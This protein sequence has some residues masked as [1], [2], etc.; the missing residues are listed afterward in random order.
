M[1]EV[2]GLRFQVVL[3]WFGWQGLDPGFDVFEIGSEVFELRFMV[4]GL[5]LGFEVL[6]PGFDYILLLVFEEGFEFFGM[7]FEVVGF[8]SE[9]CMS[10]V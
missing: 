7:L 6:R 3:G 9:N 8:G 10:H 4:L 5:T 2:L 1:L